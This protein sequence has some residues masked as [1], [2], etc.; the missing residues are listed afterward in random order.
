MTTENN[1][2]AIKGDMLKLAEEIIAGRRI[3]R[4]DDLSIFL[5]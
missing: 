5:T 1:A 3:N 4:Q 2:T